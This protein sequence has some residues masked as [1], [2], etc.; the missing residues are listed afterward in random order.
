MILDLFA[1]PGGWSTGLRS[2]GLSCVG[3]EWNPAACATRAAAGH[4]TIQAD[5]AS[6]P[7]ELF[8]G[9]VDGLCA[10][11]P[12]PDFSRAGKRRGL[13]GESGP[14]VFQVLR[15]AELRPR[16][17][18][19]ENVPDVLPI[20]RRF[21][22][23]LRA[24]GYSTWCG[25]LDCADY[26]VPQ[27]RLRAFLLASLDVVAQPPL[28]THAKASATGFDGHERKRWVSMAE[29]L[30]WDGDVQTCQNLGGQVG[31]YYTRSVDKP[32]PTVLANSWCWERPSTT[33]M[34]D[35]RV[36][37]PTG[38][39]DG[40]WSTHA[41]K[42]ELHELAILQG[43]RPDYPFQGNKTQRAQQIGN[44]VPP[45]MAAALVGCLTGCEWRQAA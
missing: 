26:G 28:P 16:W 25:V 44:A 36:F 12:C 37:P 32:S 11:P 41:I 31:N 45:P 2:L 20:W 9:K 18:A 6:Y 39:H 34:G 5:I 40:V 4:A 43:F 21:R 24:M 29:A 33:V 8:R 19:C 35:R 42:V 38:H 23:E 30:G 17:M 3:I 27:N 10:S 22:D 7:I 14:L 15:W 13:E 1:G